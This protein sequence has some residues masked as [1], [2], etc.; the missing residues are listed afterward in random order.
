M[1]KRIYNLI[2]ESKD[3]GDT[4]AGDDEEPLMIDY[5]QARQAQQN[6]AQMIDVRERDEWD[7][8]HIAGALFYPV[9]RI[10]SDPEVDV[11]PNTPIVTYCKAGGRAER[12]AEVLRA[13]G[14][15]DVRA[16]SGGFA[17]WQAAGYP[18]E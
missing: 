2:R 12:A 10:S 9:T 16:M 1:L 4:A 14:Y 3:A 17:D 7:A 5:E 15:R 11:D 8:G 18:T 6:G 13:A